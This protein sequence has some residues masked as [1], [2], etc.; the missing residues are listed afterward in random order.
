MTRD[1]E[2][3]RRVRRP[4][5]K[6]V[7]VAEVSAEDRLA[8][9]W[10]FLDEGNAG[11]AQ[12][13]FALAASKDPNDARAKLGFALA[14]AQLG[15]DARALWSAE[16]AVRVDGGELAT[17]DLSE[18]C[19]QVLAGLIDRWNNDG[20]PI[21]GELSLA[22]A[23]AADLSPTEP[24]GATM[25]ASTTPTPEPVRLSRTRPVLTSG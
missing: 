22:L 6:P 17:L 2:P 19:R 10:R 11:R 4:D 3:S 15:D 20:K 14:S 21:A 25:P 9:A 8:D 23:P 13:Y 5:P 7:V 1:A 12:G 24:D 18:S 16:R